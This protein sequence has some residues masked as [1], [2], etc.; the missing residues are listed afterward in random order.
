[1]INFLWEKLNGKRLLILGFGKEGQSSIILLSQIMPELYIGIADN[2]QSV[3]DNDLLVNFDRTRLHLGPN[4]LDSISNYDFI[5]KSPGVSLSNIHISSDIVVSSQTSLFL[6]FYNSQTIGVTGTKGKSTTS[7]L[8]H[9]LLQKLGKKSILIGNIGKPAFDSVTQ[10]DDDTN[11]VF[12]LSAHQ[13][14]YISYSPH[15]SILLNIFPE[16]L[17]YFGSVYNY[18]EAKMN[19]ARYQKANDIIICSNN[20]INDINFHSK[21]ICF[22]NNDDCAAFYEN[23]ML[24]FRENESLKVVSK[25]NVKLLGEHNLLNIMAAVLAIK[26]LGVSV[27]EM[28]KYIHE[29][30]GLPHRLES[31]GVY[32]GIDFYND[33]IS[34]VPES[35]IE[36]IKTLKSV[37]TIILGGFDRGLDYSHLAEYL[38]ASGI[39]N[40]IF[41][42]KAG[43]AIRNELNL[44][45]AKDNGFY[46]VQDLEEAFKVIKKETSKNGVC[47]LSPAAS[48][49]DQFKNFEHR[50]DLFADLARAIAK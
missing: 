21:T 20:L 39:R 49:Y 3:A 9:F 31:I 24:N 16:H 44:L 6:E 1:M 38:V 7:S 14:E 30:K 28:S 25:E 35:T 34:T 10:I 17:D 12:E 50:G 8:I 42:G 40:Y 13:L 5:L 4:Y 41:I 48:S 23:G 2:N 15:I 19:I 36:A 45:A 27:S 26:E 37:D 22:G 32:G 43:D 46:S 18:S 29:F 11:I 33:S 47:L